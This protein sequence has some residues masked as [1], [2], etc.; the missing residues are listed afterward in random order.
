MGKYSTQICCCEGPVELEVLLPLSPGR[1][2]HPMSRYIRDVWAQERRLELLPK[3]GQQKGAHFGGWA[4]KIS[5][6]GR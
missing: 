6:H 3:D 2:K 4:E 5:R 1:V